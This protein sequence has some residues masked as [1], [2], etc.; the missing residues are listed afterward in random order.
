MTTKADCGRQQEGDL[1]PFISGLIFRW[2]LAGL[3][4]EQLGEVVWVCL[5]ELWA[6]CLKR[7]Q[8]GEREVT[9]SFYRQDVR[10]F[11][12]QLQRSPLTLSWRHSTT[13]N[14]LFS[15]PNRYL[16]K[17]LLHSSG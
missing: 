9:S 13:V 4:L 17:I 5:R 7:Q 1:T 14:R 6:H 3:C 10:C 12:V 11:K 8:L 15:Y 16:T 2:K